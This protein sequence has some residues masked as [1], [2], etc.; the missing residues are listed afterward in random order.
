MPS[1]L[2][3]TISSYNKASSTLTLTRLFTLSRDNSILYLMVYVHDILI[4]GSSSPL[5]NNLIK[6]LATHFS[7]KDLGPFHYLLGI[8]A[9]SI[10]DGLFLCQQKYIKDLHIKTRMLDSKIVVTSFSAIDSFT[11]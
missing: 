4:T 9:I 8:K 2:N 7:L 11:Y 1:A 3:S 6:G 5:I 10:N